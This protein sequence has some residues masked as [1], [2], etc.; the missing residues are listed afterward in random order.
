MSQ[1]IN[2]FNPLFRQQKK[3]FSALT[4]LQAIGIILLGAIL[5]ALYAGYRTSRLEGEVAV[6][7]AQAGAA[8]DQLAK[9]TAAL[10]PRQKN[11]AL[12]EQVRK[13]EADM[14]SLQKNAAMLQSGELGNTRGY[15]EYLRAF[16]RQIV[17]GIWLT[18]FSIQAAGSEVGLQ[19]R[20]VRPELVP[21]YINRL[22]NEPVMQGKS[23]SA[24]EMRLPPTPDAASA[25]AAPAAGYIEFNL[26]STGP[27][28]PA[29]AGGARKQ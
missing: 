14:A 23:F 21:T 22:K 13:M 12:G 26:Q 20:T 2:L 6:A 17:D 25:K 28:L 4:M 29:D 24:L 15:A 16:A 27:S 3:Y 18:G 7:A 1:Q 11:K 19:G 5:L 8:Q 9:V 10:P